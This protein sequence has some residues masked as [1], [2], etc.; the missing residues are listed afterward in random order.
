[1]VCYTF[2]RLI[3]SHYGIT[4]GQ[5]EI[6]GDSRRDWMIVVARCEPELIPNL[7]GWGFSRQPSSSPRDFRISAYFDWSSRWI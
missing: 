1:M 2:R 4:K 3:L 5:R 7:R 6:A